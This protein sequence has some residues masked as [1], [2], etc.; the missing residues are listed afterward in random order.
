MEDA[1]YYEIE[2]KAGRRDCFHSSLELPLQE[3]EHVIV[4]AD[5]GE[6]LGRAVRLLPAEWLSRPPEELKPIVRRANNDE[7]DQMLRKFENER[8][9]LVTCR[10]KAKLHCLPMKILDAEY[11][12]DRHKLSFYFT[13]DTRIDFREL[14]RDL[15]ALFK[16]RIEL[17]QIGV[18]DE[19]KRLGGVGSCGRSLCCASFLRDFKPILS[20]MVKEQ[21][22]GALP[23]H[24]TGAC[25]RLKCCVRYEPEGDGGD[26]HSRYHAHAAEIPCAR[27]HSS[28]RGCLAVQ[29]TQVT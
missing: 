19:A 10:L 3:G 23:S 17:R 11:Q 6:D 25:G 8:E 26:A 12:F 29:S 27:S 9:A 24:L 5:R 15:A 21:H 2:F 1:K 7:L 18:R 13:A 20:Q 22:M 14:V 16:T 28:S 4:E